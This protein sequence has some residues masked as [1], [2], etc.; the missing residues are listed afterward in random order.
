[1]DEL[2]ASLNRTLRGWANYFRH[3]VSKAVFSTIDDHAWHRIVRWIFHKHSRLSWRELRRRFCRPGSW[4]LI[5]DGVEF[6]GASSVKVIRYRYRGSNI[7]TPWTP[8][9]AAANTGG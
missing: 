7:P 9:P 1:M 6:T 4:K 5:C 8:R 3:G 2:L